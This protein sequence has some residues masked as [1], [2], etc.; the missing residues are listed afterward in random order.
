VW[1]YLEI[2][3][4]CL[5]AGDFFVKSEELCNVP[6]A[7]FANFPPHILRCSIFSPGEL[8]YIKESK[9]IHFII[10]PEGMLFFCTFLKIIFF[11]I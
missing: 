3:H 2:T 1:L 10:N 8:L 7:L 11:L 5:V 6:S 4:T 9:A